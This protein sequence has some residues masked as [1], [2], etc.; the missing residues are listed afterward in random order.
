MDND[1]FK[2]KKL[3]E[4]MKQKNEEQ[5]R[6][7]SRKRLLAN[8]SKKFRTTMIGALA[9]FEKRFSQL[10]EQDEELRML[11]EEAR[12]EVL[13]IGNKSLRAAEQEISEYTISWNRYK[14]EFLHPT[15]YSK[16]ITQKENL[17]GNSDR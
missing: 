5:Y 8:V 9:A 7:N 14:A 2:M 4:T 16:R 13:D 17:D 15:E 6:F 3:H 10:W 12:T 1:F 11:W